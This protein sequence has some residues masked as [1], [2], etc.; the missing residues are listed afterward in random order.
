[1]GATTA[2]QF[3]HHTWSPWRGCEHATLPCGSDHPGC[4]NCYA[5]RMAK[6]NPAVLGEWGP[7]G[8][9]PIGAYSYMRLPYQWNRAAE[10]AGER[11]RVFL[12]LLD[13]FEDRPDLVEP[14]RALFQVIDDCQ[15]LDWMLFTKRPQHV[16]K[17]WV[18]GRRDNVWL[19]YSASDQP[20]LE[21]YIV[22]L[23]ACRDLVRF[24]GLSLEPL[25][26]PV[27]LH[28][29]S[30]IGTW[31]SDGLPACDHCCWG[32]R[33]DDPGHLYRPECH[34]CHGTGAALK[35]DHVIVG[36]ESGPGARPIDIAWIRSIRDQCQAAKVPLYVKQW[37]SNPYFYQRH[38][39]APVEHVEWVK[40][41]HRKGGDPAEWTADLRVRELPA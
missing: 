9:R 29:P 8:K 10:K 25:I 41:T 28:L 21:A 27:D 14:R 39:D 20:S 11:R 38:G 12:S 31:R 4:K 22:D 40:T 3:T 18:G 2:I 23:L 16:R 36:G 33:C 7:H 30:K 5:E 17:L 1:M 24:V 26:G 15:H 6:R 13:P 19:Y 34:F 32:D 37:G 35:P